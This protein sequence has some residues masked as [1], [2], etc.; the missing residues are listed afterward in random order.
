MRKLLLNLIITALFCMSCNTEAGAFDNTLWLG[1]NKG[2]SLGVL[3]VNRAGKILRTIRDTEATGIAIDTK[4]NLIFFG[5]DVGQITARDLNSPALPIR[6]LNP[7]VVNGRDMA[8]DGIFLWRTDTGNRTVQKI[9]P[10]TGAVV[11]KFLPAF[12]VIG[13]AWDGQ[14]LWLSEYNGWKG[15]ERIAQFTPKGVPT[16]VSFRTHLIDP[17]NGGFDLVGGL[18]FDSTDNTLW[19]GVRNRLVHYTTKGAVIGSV[20]I[21]GT[22]RFIDG[23]EFQGV[24]ACLKP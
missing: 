3:N 14:N 12:Y 4:K 9:N 7:P 17:I 21:A 2:A 6:T 1:N 23:L 20:P 19:L 13:I 8:F 24:A 10:I 11:F 16:G 22:G 15:N 18:A 5:G